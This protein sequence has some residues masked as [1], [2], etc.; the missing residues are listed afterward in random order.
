MG[1]AA[2][3][4]GADPLRV[5]CAPAHACMASGGI[6]ADPRA[7]AC[8]VRGLHTSAPR[9]PRAVG[10]TEQ[11][12]EQPRRAHSTLPTAG[13]DGVAERKHQRRGAEFRAGDPR[14]C[15]CGRLD[16]ADS[17]DRLLGRS[18]AEGLGRV[19]WRQGR[20]LAGRRFLAD[21]GQPVR[22]LLSRAG[23]RRLPRR[24]L[25]VELRVDGHAGPRLF[26]PLH[27]PVLHPLQGQHDARVPRAS[28]RPPLAPP[29]RPSGRW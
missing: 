9:R 28:L 1:L 3:G 16:P 13:D 5:S 15:G 10:A 26:R 8:R 17:R 23:R 12:G 29:T 19:P 4:P 22:H 20:D 25:G 24:D 7:A 21:G 18:G 6:A 27:P 14:P 2:S 11:A